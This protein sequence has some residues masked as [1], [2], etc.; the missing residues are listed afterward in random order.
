ME[1]NLRP[2]WKSEEVR[3]KEKQIQNSNDNGKDNKDML[4]IQQE[5]DRVDKR[6]LDILGTM[7]ILVAWGIT[8]F[9]TGFALWG[10]DNECCGTLR[11]WRRS[12][13]LP[14]GILLEGHGWWHLFTGYGA[15]C[16]IVW[17]IHLR[18]ILNRRQDEYVLVWPRLW[19]LPE[20]VR[21]PKKVK[22]KTAKA[23]SMNG[24][25]VNGKAVNGK[26][27]NGHAR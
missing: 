7:W 22:G 10:V 26:A 8:V 18:H 15:Y 21:T 14:W 4:S 16:Y 3:R 23:T 11:S 9:L 5:Q 27:V 2:R 20:I 6:D 24:R 19:N 13:G 12:I 1:T 25:A 17:G